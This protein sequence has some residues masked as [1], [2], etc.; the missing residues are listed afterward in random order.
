M[1]VCVH[2]HIHIRMLYDAND[3][4]L[5]SIMRE[6]EIHASPY[7]TCTFMCMFIIYQ[8]VYACILEIR[9]HDWRSRA[10]Q[11]ICRDITRHV[12]VWCSE[13]VCVAVCCSLMQSVAVCSSLMQSDAV[14]CSLLQSVALCCIVLSLGGTTDLSRHHVTEREYS[15]SSGERVRGICGKRHFIH[16]SFFKFIFPSYAF[17]PPR[18]FV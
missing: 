16:L 5:F 8:H 15:V 7:Y 18:F 1:Y 6:R 11:W 9:L 14:W 3:V 12:K 2:T 13:R 17:S 10:V 4:Y